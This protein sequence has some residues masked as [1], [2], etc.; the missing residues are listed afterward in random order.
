MRSSWL[1]L[2]TRSVRLGGTGLD[3]AGVQRHRQ[4]G[5]RRVLG[6]ARTVRSNGGVA[7]LVGHLNGL[8]R[9]RDRTDLVQLDQDG[10]ARS[11]G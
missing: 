6:L 9:L 4:V 10:V 8:Q 7:S 1:Y 5:D 2:A 11:P 3:L